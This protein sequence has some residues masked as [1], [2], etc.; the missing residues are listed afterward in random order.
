M[1]ERRETWIKKIIKTENPFIYLLPMVCGFYLDVQIHLFILFF[2]FGDLVE[3]V[4]R[5][6]K[7]KERIFVCVGFIQQK[8]NGLLFEK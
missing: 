6:R 5:R 3:G 8:K 2:F 4:K 1:K 7:K